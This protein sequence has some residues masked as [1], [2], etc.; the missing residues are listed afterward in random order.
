MDYLH[1]LLNL[2]DGVIEIQ[3]EILMDRHLNALKGE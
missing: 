2:T 3:Y 1:Y